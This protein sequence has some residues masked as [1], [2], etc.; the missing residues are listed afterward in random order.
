VHTPARGGVGDLRGGGHTPLRLPLPRAPEYPTGA[1][2]LLSPAPPSGALGSPGDAGDAH[3]SPSRAGGAG[4]GGARSV[5]GAAGAALGLAGATELELERAVVELRAANAALRRELADTRAAG[6][7]AAGA[8]ARAERAAL[9]HAAKEADLAAALAAAR[10]PPV[11]PARP[12]TDKSSGAESV[13]RAARAARDAGGGGRRTGRACGRSWT[14]RARGALRTKPRS[15][16][17]A[18]C[19]FRRGDGAR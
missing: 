19:S 16:S 9:L 2:G 10:V 8:A 15:A 11:C 1:S 6:D 12:S 14:G 7:E 3:G 13:G 5:A 4:A 18:G 17:G